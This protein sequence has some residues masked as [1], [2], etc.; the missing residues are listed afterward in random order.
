[1]RPNSNRQCES[2]FLNLFRNGVTQCNIVSIIATLISFD[3]IYSKFSE[4]CPTLCLIIETTPPAFTKKICK[5]SSLLNYVPQAPSHITCL[6]A[7]VPYV[8]Y[9]RASS[10]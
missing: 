1:M 8:P 7:F 3:L 6:R 9:L 4:L 2:N 5:N 10:K